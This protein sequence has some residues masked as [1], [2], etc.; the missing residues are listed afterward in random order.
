MTKPNF[1]ITGAPKA[2]TSSLYNYL[3]EDPQIYMS[4]IKEPKFFALEGEN[5]DF[6]G[7]QD[8]IKDYITDIETYC[9]LFNNLK[10]EIAIGEASPWYLS[11]YP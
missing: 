10:Q 11:L 1:L 3:N 6:Q 9:G 5:V 7:P 4:L 8:Y 2:G